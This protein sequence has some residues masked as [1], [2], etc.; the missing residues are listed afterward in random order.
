MGA[1]SDS[2]LKSFYISADGKWDKVKSKSPAR[3][4]TYQYAGF[5]LGVEF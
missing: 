2:F 1:V 4:S 5:G 3:N